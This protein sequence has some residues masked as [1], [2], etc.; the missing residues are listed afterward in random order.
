MYSRYIL[1]KPCVGG[2]IVGIRPG[3]SDHTKD[4]L[5][6]FQFSLDNDDRNQIEQVVAKGSP[7]RTKINSKCFF[8]FETK[9]TY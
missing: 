5:K 3:L 1:D 9:T 8:I 2:V 6:V 4:N 7:L